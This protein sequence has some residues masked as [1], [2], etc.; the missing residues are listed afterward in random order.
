LRKISGIQNGDDRHLYPDILN[1]LIAK[2]Q[3]PVD[4]YGNPRSYHTFQHVVDGLTAIR[5]LVN[6]QSLFVHNYVSPVELHMLVVAYAFHDCVYHV[7][8]SE[9]SKTDTN[10]SLSAE[11]CKQILLGLNISEKYID[12]IVNLILI[13]DPQKV[14]VSN[15]EKLIKDIDL[16]N[17]SSAILAEKANMQIY[18]EYSGV[19]NKNMVAYLKK[20]KLFWQNYLN[21]H[22]RIFCTPFFDKFNKIALSN[23]LE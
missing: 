16:L 17:L 18:N 12:S 14:P 10:E 15:I 22:G 4:G 6:E 23:I 7:Q 13:T 5:D 9:E 20:R 19:L 11:Y 1:S 3:S 21:I 2:Y 8:S